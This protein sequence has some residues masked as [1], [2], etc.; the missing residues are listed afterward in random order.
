MEKR[1]A[2]YQ[3]TEEYP[4]E[5]FESKEIQRK[6][7]DTPIRFRVGAIK[8]RVGYVRKLYLG[9]DELFADIVVNL[10]EELK[11]EEENGEI[12]FSVKLVST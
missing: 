6:I 3:F 4:R 12:F 9:R 5:F 2:L 7:G 10:K 8:K 11:I 1:V